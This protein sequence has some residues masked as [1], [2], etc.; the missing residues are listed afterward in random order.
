MNRRRFR[1]LLEHLKRKL[2]FRSGLNFRRRRHIVRS[3]QVQYYGIY[4]AEILAVI[5]AALFITMGFGIRVVCSGEA[6]ETAIPENATTWVNRFVYK[7][8][9]PKKGEVIAFFPKG[10]AGASLNM[11]RVIAVEGDT[12]LISNGKLYVNEELID[13]GDVDIKDAGRAANLITL[14]K[15]EFFV[16]GDNVNNSEDSRYESVGNVKRD[17]IYGRAWFVT[18]FHGFG[19]I[20]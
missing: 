2:Q 7:V 17:E 13:M 5:L 15:D 8:S 3:E 4:A 18:S 11:K 6:M 16:L 1:I 12:V 14:E 20:K 19:T 9:A 10:N